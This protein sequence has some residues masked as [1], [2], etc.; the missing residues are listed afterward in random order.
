MHVIVARYYTKAG[1]DDEVA[2]I[3]RA[4]IPVSHSQP[5]CKTFAVNRAKDDPRRFLLY[6][7]FVDEAAYADH[8]ALAP[9]Q[10]EIVGKVFPMLESRER[11]VY[12]TVDPE[13][14]RRDIVT[15]RESQ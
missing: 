7:Q 12:E 14:P 9:I 2:A 3:L 5:G 10:Q 8:V 6:E 11:E 13:S 15:T 4:M 1:K